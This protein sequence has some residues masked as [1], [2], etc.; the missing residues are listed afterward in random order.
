[1]NSYIE[2]VSEKTGGMNGQFATDRSFV[3]PHISHISLLDGLKMILLCAWKF[4]KKDAR[5]S[6]ERNSYAKLGNNARPQFGEKV[7]GH[8][9][10][11]PCMARTT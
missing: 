5:K 2:Q 11:P 1:M 7:S 6:R 10:F 9:S 8:L 3:N 4:I